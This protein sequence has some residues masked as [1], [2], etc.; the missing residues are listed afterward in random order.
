[1]K[2]KPLGDLDPRETPTVSVLEAA[3]YLG[4]GRDAAYN[5]A[6]TGDIP[7]LRLGTKLRV[8]TAGLLKMLGIGESEPEPET[9][10]RRRYRVAS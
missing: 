6:R 4:I 5:A 7:T 10:K 8:P 9:P 1:M 3:E 2:A